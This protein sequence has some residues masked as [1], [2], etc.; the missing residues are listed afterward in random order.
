[1]M[2]RKY[3]SRLDATELPLR[4]IFAIPHALH[5][6]SWRYVCSYE[7]GSRY[8]KRF[9]ADMAATYR[10]ILEYQMEHGIIRKRATLEMRLP[11]EVEPA[12]SWEWH[13]VVERQHYADVDVTG[14]L[15]RL[16]ETELPCV[17]LAKEEHVAYNQTLHIKETNVL[18]RDMQRQLRPRD[19]VE[20]LRQL[21]R[22]T[23]AGDKV[24][25][26]IAENVFR[27]VL[28]TIR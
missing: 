5:H 4:G 7:D 16:Y 11:E 25:T 2:P 20:R 23:Y 1:M 3:I 26:T 22:D 28:T 21:Y 18:Y 8:K 14:Q 9:F 27:D 19:R 13:H 10:S 12:S 24:L 17:L 6:D 15:Q